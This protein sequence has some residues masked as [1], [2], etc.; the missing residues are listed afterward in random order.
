MLR[1]ELVGM[2]GQAFAQHEEEMDQILSRLARLERA[3][4]STIDE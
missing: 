4:P 1:R 3:P 2:L